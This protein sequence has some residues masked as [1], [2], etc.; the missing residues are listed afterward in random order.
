MLKDL[1]SHA[2]LKPG[3]KAARLLGVKSGDMLILDRYQKDG[4]HRVG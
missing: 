1:K 3:E 4:Q 2:H